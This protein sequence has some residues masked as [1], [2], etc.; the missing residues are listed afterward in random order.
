MAAMLLCPFASACTYLQRWWQCSILI[1]SQDMLITMSMTTSMYAGASTSGSES[2]AEGQNLLRMLW[3][4]DATDR[5]MFAC[6]AVV[7]S[8]LVPGTTLLLV[9]ALAALRLLPDDPVCTLSVLI[10]VRAP[11]LSFVQ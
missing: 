3:P 8:L 7:R 11:H 9:R 6:V 4:A 10:Q 2:G 1:S 5:R